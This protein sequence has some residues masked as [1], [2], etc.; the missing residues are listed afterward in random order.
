MSF[1]L[2]GDLDVLGDI[3]NIA[4]FASAFFSFFFRSF[5]G[6]PDER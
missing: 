4:N 1:F 5:L 6:V 2:H 3:V